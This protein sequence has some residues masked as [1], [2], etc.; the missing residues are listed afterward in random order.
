MP[1]AIISLLKSDQ[2]HIRFSE[3]LGEGEQNSEPI[4]KLARLGPRDFYHL[5]TNIQKT[6]R[7]KIKKCYFE[8]SYRNQKNGS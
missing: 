4:N 7:F 6:K 5:L 8:E 2:M 1:E 3:D